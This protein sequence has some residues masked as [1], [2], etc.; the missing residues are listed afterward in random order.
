MLDK[1]GVLDCALEKVGRAFRLG[2][3]HFG[4]LFGYICGVLAIESWAILQPRDNL[5]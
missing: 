3:R 2:E 1:K 5:V 4:H